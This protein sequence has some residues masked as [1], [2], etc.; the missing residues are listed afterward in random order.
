MA[1]VSLVDKNRQWFKSRVGLSV[2]ETSRDFSFCAHAILQPDLFIVRDATEDA[3]L[4][5][6]P[7][8]TGEPKIRFYTGIP[9]FTSDDHQ[10]LGTMDSLGCHP[11]FHKCFSDTR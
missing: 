2:A 1:L 5:G 11:G 9:L 7:L 8:V 6:N 10:A 4:S 3:S